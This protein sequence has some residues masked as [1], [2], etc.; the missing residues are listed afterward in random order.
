M[1]L[2]ESIV[3]NELNWEGQLKDWTA[4]ED[5]ALDPE[6]ASAAGDD[7]IPYDT[8]IS[9]HG[10]QIFVDL[11]RAGLPIAC[12]QVEIN[13]GVPAI[14]V[15]DGIETAVHMHF[16]DRGIVIVPDSESFATAPVSRFSYNQEGGIV[17]PWDDSMDLDEIRREVFNLAVD[18]QKFS[19][20]VVAKGDCDVEEEF[21]PGNNRWSMWVMLEGDKPSDEATFNMRFLDGTAIPCEVYVR[22]GSTGVDA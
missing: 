1:S 7:A 8:K 14:H 4:A 11:S 3:P 21:G 18:A 10:E 13:N 19:G 16:A 17:V 15:G 9:R 6:S 2:S 22:D 5:A 12:I 20:L